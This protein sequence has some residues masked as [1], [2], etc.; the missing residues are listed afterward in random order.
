MAEG[1]DRRQLH[2]L[3]KTIEQ[4]D[5]PERKA[6]ITLARKSDPEQL[7]DANHGL[8]LAMQKMLSN[9]RK[10][11]SFKQREIS[12]LELPAEI[13]KKLLAKDIRRLENLCAYN[14]EGLNALGF[15]EREISRIRAHLGELGLAFRGEAGPFDGRE[16]PGFSEGPE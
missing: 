14:E 3:R 4:A 13:E 12:C 15:D 10:E 2:A 11:S 9:R 6:L 16:P 1:K 8:Y 5:L 7:R